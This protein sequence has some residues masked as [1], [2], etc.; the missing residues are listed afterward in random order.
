MNGDIRS[1]VS[2]ITCGDGYPAQGTPFRCDCGGVFDFSHFPAYALPDFSNPAGLWRYHAALAL[3]E[4]SPVI[5][6][7]EGDTPLLRGNFQGIP[8][9]F[10]MESQNPTA[11]YKDRGSAV[12]VSFLRSRLVNSVVEDSSGNAGASLAAYCARAG[13]SA[14]IFIPESASGPKRWQIEMYGAQ[15]ERVAGPRANAAAAVLQAAQSGKVYASHAYMPFGLA[16]IATIAYELFAQLGEVPGTILAPVG[17][18]GLLYGV[19]LGFEALQAADL[20]QN[21]PYYIGVQ[22]DACAPAV[23]AY[24]CGSR[25]VS[26]IAPGFTLA[27]GASVAQPMRASQILR[28]MLEGGG[29][30]VG[31]SEQTLVQ[32]YDQAARQGIFVEPT[33]CLP[34]AALRDDKIELVQPVVSILTG[35][36]LK[37]NIIPK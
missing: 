11:S 12:L 22:A 1:M 10:K 32:A 36:G 4:D 34:L 25:E 29:R 33:A 3:P 15:V 19:M 28:R 7:G 6:L 5:T 31:V 14:Q 30:M 37:T 20:I 35:S 17:H 8:V 16:G 23:D 2:C 26:E 9:Y 13:I 27:E 18:G 21:L 24:R